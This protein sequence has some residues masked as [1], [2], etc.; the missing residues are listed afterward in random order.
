MIFT[1]APLRGVYLID[2]EKYGD[3]RGFLRGAS[4]NGSL[5]L[6]VWPHGLSRPVIHTARI[7]ERFA[8]CTTSSHQRPRL[9]SFG[10]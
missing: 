5:L 6:M 8:E 3:E 7:R 9:S 4:V 10:V 2:L 1:E